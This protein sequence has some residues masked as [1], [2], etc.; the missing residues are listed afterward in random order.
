MKRKFIGL[1]L[2]LLG[3]GTSASN[4]DIVPPIGLQPGDQYRLIVPGAAYW[5]G[6]RGGYLEAN[7]A[8]QNG[9]DDDQFA[10][11]IGLLGATWTAVLANSPGDV[12][13]NTG[14]NPDVSVGV[15][16]YQT[17][18]DRVAANNADLWDGTIETAIWYDGNG[19][20]LPLNSS[21]WQN[22]FVHLNGSWGLTCLLYT[23]D[24]ADEVSPV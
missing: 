7:E 1:V 12:E 21:K 9:A 10:T 17:N 23:S 6:N 14:T 13:N 24:A 8:A 22:M 15:P 5:A 19:D 18:G 3:C 11:G 20:H 4:A 16:I 2:A